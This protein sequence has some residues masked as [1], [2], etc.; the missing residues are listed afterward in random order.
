MIFVGLGSNMGERLNYLTEGIRGLRKKEVIP[1]QLSAVY[2]TPAWGGKASLPFLNAVA[3]V[4][5]SGTPTELLHI[6]LEVEASCGRVRTEKWGNRTLDLDL[7]SWGDLVLDS[8]ELRLPHPYLQER[9]FVLGPWQELA[10]KYPLP[11]L[12]KTVGEAWLSLPE[13]ERNSLQR[14]P[15]RIH[16]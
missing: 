13:T 11:G 8:P 10:P 7:L 6:F 2:E 1:V 4:R 3:E 14:H 15:Y 9:A 16:E 5:F 12:E